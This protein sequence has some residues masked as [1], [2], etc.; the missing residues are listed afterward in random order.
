[1]RYGARSPRRLGITDVARVYHLGLSVLAFG[2]AIYLIARGNTLVIV[3]LV[4]LIILELVTLKLR[5][6]HER[7]RQ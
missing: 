7:R 4:G 1:L 3:P 5:R 2:G 6:D